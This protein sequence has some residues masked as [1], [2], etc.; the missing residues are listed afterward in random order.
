MI[1][2]GVISGN[3]RTK[4][5]CIHGHLITGKYTDKSGRR[6][7]RCLTCHREWERRRRQGDAAYRKRRSDTSRAWAKEHPDRVSA[8]SKRYREKVNW[9][10]R[11]EALGLCID[12]KEKRHPGKRRCDYH[13]LQKRLSRREKDSHVTVEQFTAALATHGNAC[14]IC[15]RSDLPLHADHDHIAKKFRGP[16]CHLCNRAI[17]L[18]QDSPSLCDA[19]AHYLRGHG[20]A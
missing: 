10:A 5:T 18:L 9:A 11:Q 20:K 12:C 4:P 3:Q 19:A 13:L 15:R 6:H 7:R 1:A 8:A 16:L 14:A 2:L 17:G